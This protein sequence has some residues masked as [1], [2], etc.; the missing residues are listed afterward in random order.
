MLRNILAY[1]SQGYATSGILPTSSILKKHDVFENGLVSVSR[2]MGR[3]A[4]TLQDP[5]ETNTFSH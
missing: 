2:R 5:T 4:S 3:K 1:Y